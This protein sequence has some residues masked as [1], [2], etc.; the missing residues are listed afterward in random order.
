M[1]PSGLLVALAPSGLAC[2]SQSPSAASGSDAPPG[3]GPPAASPSPAPTPAPPGDGGAYSPCAGKA[4][5]ETCTICSPAATD[6]ME[7]MVVKQC[8]AQG[9]CSTDPVDCPK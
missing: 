7:T 6:C 2:G 4:C 3:E 5:G 8:N 1:R 9:A